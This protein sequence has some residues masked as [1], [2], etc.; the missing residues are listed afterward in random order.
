MKAN[1]WFRMYHEFATDPKVQMLSEADQRRFIM[2]LCLRCCNG[3]VTLQDAEVAFQLRITDAEWADT[4]ARLL[5]KELIDENNQ[6]TN[7][8]KRQFASDRSN[9]RVSRHRAKSKAN[10]AAAC[11]VTVTPPDTESDT[12]S[13]TEE[14]LPVR[15]ESDAVRANGP[16]E[17]AGLNGSTREIVQGIAKFL[18]SM[19]PDYATAKIIVASN[20]GIYGGVAV[21]DGYAELMA[22]MADNKVRVPTVKALVGYFKTASNR[23]PGAV[24]PKPSN[25]FAAQRIE[26]SRAFSAIIEQEFAA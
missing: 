16:D 14:V 20:V 1:P 4:K 10:G 9:E 24:P 3:D 8:D 15:P 17:I 26:R 22:D 11:N 25:D 23:T 21:R 7:W 19:A 18:N 13:E 2:V 12:D 6:P 5:A